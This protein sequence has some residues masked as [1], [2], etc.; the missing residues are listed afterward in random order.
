MRPYRFGAISDSCVFSADEL[1]GIREAMAELRFIKRGEPSDSL[2]F[3]STVLFVYSRILSLWEQRGAISKRALRSNIATAIAEYV[4]SHYS[5][6]IS[7]RVLAEKFSISYSYLSKIMSRE[8]GMSLG[9]YIISKR[10]EQAK[11]LLIATDESVA[12]I[13][14]ECGFASSSAFISHFKSQTGKTPLAFRKTAHAV[15]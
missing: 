6:C 15:N 7:A 3:C 1:H 4:S 11:R 12:E 5:E 9:D 13:A 2:R 8:F 14:Y 10:I